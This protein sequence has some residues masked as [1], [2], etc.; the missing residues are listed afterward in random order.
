MIIIKV[1]FFI[2]GLI[3][4]YLIASVDNI[5]PFK[6]LNIT[7]LILDIFGLVLLSEYVFIKQ[8]IAAKYSD[9]V[10][11]IIMIAFFSIS[12]G[13]IIGWGFSYWFSLPSSYAAGAFLVGL[14]WYIGLPF[15]VF[16]YLTDGFKILQSPTKRAYAIGFY[17]LISG[18]LVQLV[19]SFQDLLNA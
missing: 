2:L 18:L 17:M 7:G 8:D 10:E 15:L 16:S 5:E 6:L 13:A 4:F 19:A 11:S 3:F 12:G 1:I 9:K 14:T